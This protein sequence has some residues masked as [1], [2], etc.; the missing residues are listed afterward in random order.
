M[1]ELLWCNASW[2]ILLLTSLYFKV[3]LEF[4]YNEHF[5][6][7]KKAIASPLKIKTKTKK[8]KEKENQR[9]DTLSNQLCH[10]LTNVFAPL[11]MIATK[12]ITMQC[13]QG[14]FHN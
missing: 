9:R 12:E 1:N 11:F 14:I 10:I 4:F 8:K 6:F 3:L 2:N 5:L 13:P 7:L